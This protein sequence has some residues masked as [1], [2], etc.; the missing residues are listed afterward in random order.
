M[1][2]LQQSVGIDFRDNALRVVHLGR[3]FK[4]IVLIDYFMKKYPPSGSRS[5]T[6]DEIDPL[7]LDL[8][9]FIRERGIKPDQI[10]IGLP[11]KEVIL[12]EVIMPK[13]DE[14]ELLEMLAYEL[15]RHVPFPVEQVLFDYQILSRDE[16][17]LRLLLGIARKDDVQKVMSLLEPGQT[18]S[19]VMDITSIAGMN[20]LVSQNSLDESRLT[21]FIDV[22][23]DTV[24]LGIMEGKQMRVSRS[25]DRNKSRLEGAYTEKG[26]DSPSLKSAG[27]VV[28]PYFSEVIDEDVSTLGQDIIRELTVAL[29]AVPQITEERRIDDLI[30]TGIDAYDSFVSEY[31]IKNTG[32]QIRIVNP[33]KNIATDKIPGKI[34]S[35]LAVATGL[36][37]RGLDDQPLMLNFLPEGRKARRKRNY[38]AL[39][40]TSLALII[41]LTLGWILGLTY[42][43]SLVSS[44]L[45][46]QLKALQPDVAA[47]NK[48]SQDIEKVEQELSMIK[49]II[50]VEVSKL[51]LL[52]ELTSILPADT[53]LDRLNVSNETLE[54]NGYSEAP[55]NLIP[56]LEISS[57]LQNVQFASSITK[58]GPGKERFKIKADIERVGSREEEQR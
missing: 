34:S 22:G 35:S 56:M 51:N 55:S 54:I 48:M 39:T 53:W 14:K 23:E 6:E 58:L 21:A 4:D 45:S 2:Y 19:A 57:M 18:M 9:N 43:K 3:T 50:D 49:K 15:E 40:I 11:K 28:N 42:E 12:K 7:A 5:N 38:L 36:A 16:N 27:N 1:L 37:L 10:V 52:K 31:I 30:L 33:F 46:R 32:T 25:L 44:E 17:T 13:V 29:H 41:I 26:H 20:L 8:R 47:V 24:E